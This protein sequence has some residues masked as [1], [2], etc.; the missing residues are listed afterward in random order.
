MKLAANFYATWAMAL[1]TRKKAGR[2]IP[3]YEKAYQ[4][5]TNNSDALSAYSLLLLRN[6]QFEKALEVATNA[7]KCTEKPK[8]IFNARSNR[9]LALWKL[10]RVEDA[11]RIYERLF[12]EV[13]NGPVYG[14]LGFLYIA[15]GDQTGDYEKALEFNLKAVDYDG[16]DAV[17]LDN[18]A[19]T[20]MRMERWEEAEEFFRKALSNNKDQFDSLVCLARCALRRDDEEEGRTLL[21]KALQRPFSHLN[22]VDRKLAEEM[23][24]H[25]ADKSDRR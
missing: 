23:M 4:G 12:G 18:L 5:G 25:L 20:Y 6:G 22:T 7:R 21:S 11:V 13:Q 24:E 8:K 2:A 19:Q 16:D 3:L 9:A 14:T 17:L 10:G 15:L 1:Q